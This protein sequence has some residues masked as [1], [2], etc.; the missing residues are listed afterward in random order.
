MQKVALGGLAADLLPRLLSLDEHGYFLLLFRRCH[1][2]EGRA[3]TAFVLRRTEA[4]CER[5]EI[6]AK[7]N[8]FSHQRAPEARLAAARDHER[9]QR[10]ESLALP[11]HRTR[12]DGRQA[13]LQS[14]AQ[15]LAASAPRVQP[16]ATLAGLCLCVSVCGCGGTKQRCHSAPQTDRLVSAPCVRRSR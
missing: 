1:P 13:C 11:A 15:P 4:H 16:S 9:T 2:E 10:L 7:P 12:Q 8:P 6:P 14:H 3:A 5:D